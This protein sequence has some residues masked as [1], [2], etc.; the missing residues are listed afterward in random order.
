M[1]MEDKQAVAVRE[2]EF[3]QYMCDWHITFPMN[4]LR[5]MGFFSAPASTKYHGSYTGGLYDHSKAVADALCE[6]TERN[7]IPW[8]RECSPVI[9]GMFHDLCKAD[10]YTLKSDG[11]Y[12]FRKDTLFTGHGEKSIMLLSTLMR[13]TEE[14]V[15]CI[16]FHM[17][18]FSDDPNERS[19]YSRAC[20]YYPQVLYTHTADMI[21]SQ[22]RGI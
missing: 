5:E 15:A 22:V 1:P 13:L 12:E 20:K 9:V 14:E 6:L 18:A 11:T 16:R 19:A 21:A 3:L 4:G 17:G 10:Q 2:Q 8:E 7:K